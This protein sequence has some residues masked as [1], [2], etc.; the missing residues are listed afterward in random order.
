MPYIAS[1]SEA[2]MV[3]SRGVFLCAFECIQPRRFRSICDAVTSSELSTVY[4]DVIRHA[5]KVMLREVSLYY[6]C[7]VSRC[8]R[9]TT[10]VIRLKD[11]MTLG[12][13]YA[14]HSLHASLSDDHDTCSISIMQ[15]ASL[16]IDSNVLAMSCIR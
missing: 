3:L 7:T 8:K 12:I 1:E 16:Y 6:T 10:G 15:L 9:D 13:K 2:R 4:S 11:D 5:W 14:R